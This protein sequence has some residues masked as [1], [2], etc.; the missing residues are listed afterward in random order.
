MLI[1]ASENN[2]TVKFETSEQ[3]R[4][5]WGNDNSQNIK[6]HWQEIRIL[7]SLSN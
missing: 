1:K 5:R 2:L 4:Q 3:R 7:N 6:N